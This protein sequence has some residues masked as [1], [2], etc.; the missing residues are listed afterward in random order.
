M[1]VVGLVPEEAIKRVDGGCPKPIALREL[2]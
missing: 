1:L 2:A